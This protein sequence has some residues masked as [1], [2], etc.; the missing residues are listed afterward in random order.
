MSQSCLHPPAIGRVMTPLPSQLPFISVIVP[1][2]NEARCIH[3]TLN[4]LLGQRYDPERFEILVIDGQST[5]DTRAIVRRLQEEHSNLRLLENRKQWSSAG[6]NIGVRAARGEIVVIVDGHSDVGTPD[7][8]SNL[9]KAFAQS[10]ADCIGRPQPLEVSGAS[11]LQRAISLAR[12]S[13]LGH[14]PTSW[15]YSSGA[16]FVRPQS[17]A[18]AYKRSTFERV[19]EF[20]EEFDACEDVEFNYRVDQAGMRCFFTP[21]VAVRYEPRSTIRGLFHQMRR[22]GQ[23]RVRLL[24]KHP[25]SFTLPCFLPALFLL[26][27]VAGAWL[28]WTSPVLAALYGMTLALYAFT[29]ISASAL[30]AWR[31]KE[32][33]LLPWLAMVFATIHSGAGTGILVEGARQAARRLS[34]KKSGI[35]GPVVLPISSRGRQPRP[36]L[37]LPQRPLAAESRPRQPESVLPQ[38]PTILNALTI[39]V[40]DYYQVSG[41]ENCVSR[42]QWPD[43]ESRVVASTHRILQALNDASVRGTFFVLGWIAD[44]HPKLIRTIQEAG[45]DMGCHSYWHRLV[46]N[47]TPAEFREDLRRARDVLEE[48]TGQAIVAYRAPSF[49]ITRRSLW[50]LDIL[51]EE[52]FRFDSS[53]YPTHHDRYGIAGAPNW[54]HQVVR[55][56]GTLWEFPMAIY[57]CFGYPLPIGGG[58]YLRLYPYGF[59]RHGL[60]AINAEGRPFVVY[61]HPWELDPEQPRLRPGKLKGFRHYVNLHRTESRLRRLLQDFRF[62]SLREVNAR[63]QSEGHQSQWDLT[64]AA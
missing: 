41:F 10:G 24:C 56:A 36:L 7:Y 13:R 57:R 23:G 58:G 40:E 46:Y 61:L 5:D 11:V 47:Q 62:D 6:R 2:R 39:D 28:C 3:H 53:I 37:V 44:R 38:E 27:L 29:V 16:Q 63:L 60:R 32:A 14:N 33:R 20:D 49:S 25:G 12:S 17:V 55:P 42:D 22:Y 19:G 8:L 15:I 30:L 51:I 35:K 50:A 26:G 34:R 21:T 1:V 64:A 59:T 54:P 48:I 9:A 52:G 45:H 43:F 31:A 4:Q 18:V